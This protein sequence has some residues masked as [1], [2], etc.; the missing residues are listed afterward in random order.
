VID[1]NDPGQ[2]M[3]RLTRIP[4]DTAEAFAAVRDA[5]AAIYAAADV[6]FDADAEQQLERRVLNGMTVE[7]IIAETLTDRKARFER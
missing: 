2:M 4:I 7:A 1:F 6:P 5:C 3:H